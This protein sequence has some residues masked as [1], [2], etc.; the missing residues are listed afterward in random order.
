MKST[1]GHIQVKGGKI[2]YKVFLSE[3]NTT[4][5]M[6]LHG[7][8]GSS[9][10]S[11]QTLSEF[12]KDRTVVFYDQLG[13]G[14]SDRPQ[15]TKLWKKERFVEELETLRKHLGFEEVYLWGQSWG[16]MLAVMYTLKFPERVKCIIF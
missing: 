12:S 9:S 13:S 5:L 7:G 14:H 3:K 10:H 4:P 16:T 8:P 1:E 11:M 2:W 6:V 15:D